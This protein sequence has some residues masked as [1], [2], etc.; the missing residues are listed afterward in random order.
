MAALPLALWL[1]LPGTALCGRRDRL[2][3]RAGHGALVAAAAAMNQRRLVLRFIVA[4]LAASVVA[5]GAGLV[6][7]IHTPHGP[8]PR[9]PTPTAS[10]R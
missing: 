5:W 2:P 6:W 7:F 10:S 8:S 1:A 4:V 9:R 3:H